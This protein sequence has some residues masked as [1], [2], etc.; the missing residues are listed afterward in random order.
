MRHGLLFCTLMAGFLL[1]LSG[2][3][4]PAAATPAGD[5]LP[6]S[7]KGYELYAWDDGGQNWFTLLPGTNRLKSPAE[8][9]SGEREV[10]DP[11]GGFAIT[12][13]GLDAVSGQLARLPRGTL[14]FVSTVRYPPGTTLEALATPESVALVLRQDAVAL[15]LDLQIMP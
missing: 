13:T 10:I 15:G 12:V 4:E 1:V 7:M 5:S 9:F 3:Q 11:D 8:V 2:C 14:V 6:A